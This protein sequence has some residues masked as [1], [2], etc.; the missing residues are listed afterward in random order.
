R[1]QV[2]VSGTDAELEALD[3][4]LAAARRKSERSAAR[5]ED[6]EHRLAVAKEKRAAEEHAA[7]Q[8]AAED[9]AEEGAALVKKAFAEIAKIV[10]RLSEKTQP[11]AAQ[12]ESV[13][14]RL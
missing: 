3:V 10:V 13:N 11:L 8:K 7:R 12:I 5:K 4:A 14:R 2:L 1:P 6:C 9:A